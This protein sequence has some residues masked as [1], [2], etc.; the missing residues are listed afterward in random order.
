MGRPG[1]SRAGLVTRVGVGA[2]AADDRAVGALDLAGAVGVDG[3][4][5]AEFVQDDVV[6]PPAVV[7]EVREAGVTSLGPVLDVV[8]FTARGGLVAAAKHRAA[9]YY[10]RCFTLSALVRPVA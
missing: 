1:S 8:R 9:M 2:V 7:F 10:S 3:Q 6:V 5:P 4:G